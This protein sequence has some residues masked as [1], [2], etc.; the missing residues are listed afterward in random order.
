RSGWRRSADPDRESL[1]ELAL[2]KPQGL[3][4]V[5]TDL[6]VRGAASLAD[7]GEPVGPIQ[8]MPS[9]HYGGEG[10]T[11]GTWAQQGGGGTGVCL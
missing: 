10:N 6:A 11:W 2:R 8:V 4:G 9:P 1:R 3:F 7:G 5:P